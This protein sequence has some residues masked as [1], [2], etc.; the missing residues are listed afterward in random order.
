MAKVAI[1]LTLILASLLTLTVLATYYVSKYPIIVK[2]EAQTDAPLIVAVI[3]IA[4]SAISA[5]LLIARFKNREK[6]AKPNLQL[7]FL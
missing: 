4:S 2:F 5:F 7:V 6:S 1:V 3:F